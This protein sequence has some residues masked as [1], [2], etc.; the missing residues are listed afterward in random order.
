[1]VTSFKSFSTTFVFDT[2]DVKFLFV[3]ILHNRHGRQFMSGGQ[4]QLNLEFGFHDDIPF[5]W[6]H[7]CVK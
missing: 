4:Q 6:D 2:S 3:K 7:L 5:T 1:M